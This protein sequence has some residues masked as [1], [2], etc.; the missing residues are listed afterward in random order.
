[1]RQWLAILVV[2]SLLPGCSW[3]Q[4]WGEDDDINAPAKLVEFS[5]R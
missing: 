2:A 1:M 5:P 3:I 4:S